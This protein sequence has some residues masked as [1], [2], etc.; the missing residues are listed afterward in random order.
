MDEDRKIIARIINGSVDQYRK[1]VEKYQQPVYRV[2]L[3]MTG[4]A[5]NAKELTQDVFVRAYESLEQ[6]NPEYKF[7]S[8]VYRIAIN[9]A[10][11]FIKR[12]KRFVHAEHLPEI[13]EENF[14]EHDGERMQIIKQTL[15]KMPVN[16]KTVIVLKYYAGC[17]YADIATITGE[18]EKKVKS[19]LFDGRKL[20][21]KQLLE[22][23]LF[24]N[25]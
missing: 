25:F 6:Y 16:Y 22:K 11:A 2:I 14:N 17:S 20:L 13:A 8:W 4:D 10:L 19:R 3:K 7:F 9:T 12:Q 21:K 18:E 1:L 23:G 24:N 15:Q 5:E